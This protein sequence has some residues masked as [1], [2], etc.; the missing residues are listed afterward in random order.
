MLTAPVA[1][2]LRQQIELKANMKL[3]VEGEDGLHTC[4]GCDCILNLKVWVPIKHIK[5]TTP[6]EE[7]NKENPKCWILK[8]IE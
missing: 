3:A 1:N 7:L 5:E 8:E 4:G 6:L 2:Q